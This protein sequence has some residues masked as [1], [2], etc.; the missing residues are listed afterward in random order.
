MSAYVV[1]E[2]PVLSPEQ[3]ERYQPAAAAAG[4]LAVQGQ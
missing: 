1:I 4:E 2:T 3:R